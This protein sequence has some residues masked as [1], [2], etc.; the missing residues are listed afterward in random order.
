MGGEKMYQLTIA[1]DRQES[2]IFGGIS[3]QSVHIVVPESVKNQV[4]QHF[5][6]QHSVLAVTM[7]DNS[8]RYINT[9]N[10]LF[11]DVVEVNVEVKQGENSKK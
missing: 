10:I 5:E 4:I 3:A 11:I 2:G 1:F 6:D 9:R 7:Q 8:T